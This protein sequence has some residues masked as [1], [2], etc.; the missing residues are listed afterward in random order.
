MMKGAL[1]SVPLLPPI[2]SKI[3]FQY[4]PESVKRSVKP[5]YYG[6]GKFGSARFS[7]APTENISLEILLDA[8]QGQLK[9]GLPPKGIKPELSALESLLYPPMLQVGINAVLL[10]VGTI[11]AVPLDTPLT[12][13]IFG[14]GRVVPVRLT[15]VDVTEE[16]WDSKL[17]PVRAKV[18]LSMDVVT[19]SDVGL[20]SPSGA[21]FVVHQVGL[22]SEADSVKT[23]P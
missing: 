14:P 15:G 12:L 5:N 6:A 19:Y 3:R 20:V 1:I 17:N 11:E 4:N 9:A 22:E 2:P 16:L 7:G 18:S 23:L 8:T 13:F 10:A 21:A